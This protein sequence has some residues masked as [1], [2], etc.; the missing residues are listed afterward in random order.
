MIL[1]LVLV[2]GVVVGLLL[3]Q[4]QQVFKQKASTPTGTSTLT[5]QPATA[6]F[7]RGTSNPI[8]LYFNTHGISVSGINVRLT[9][10][11]LGVTASG[12]NTSDLTSSGDWSCPVKTV[13]SNGSTDEIDIVC[14]NSAP[15]GYS[16]NVDTLL[17]TFNLTASQVPIQNP[18]IISFDPAGT[19]VTQK[20]DGA[21]IAL[22]PSSIGSYTITDTLAGSPTASPIIVVASPTATPTGSALA[23]AATATPTATATVAPT[24]TATATTSVFATVTPT[25]VPTATAFGAT[26]TAS[27]FPMPVTGF[28]APTVIGAIGG[29]SLLI[30]GALALMF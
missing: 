29:V 9:Y 26:P 22:T 1:V 3:V 10:S 6:S 12:I 28:D 15:A 25:P 16:N 7:E 13:T 30:I 11:N 4:Q 2:G 20:S 23:L 17:A 24:A 18:L 14:T 27:P 21:D 5:I 8:S 19:T